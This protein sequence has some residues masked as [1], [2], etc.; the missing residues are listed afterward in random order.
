MCTSVSACHL[1][2]QVAMKTVGAGQ[3]MEVAAAAGVTSALLPADGAGDQLL[4]QSAVYIPVLLK[5]IAKGTPGGAAPALG[6]LSSSPHCMVVFGCW[7]VRES[8]PSCVIPA[9]RW[10]AI[11]WLILEALKL[12][13]CH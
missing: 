10:R 9:I 2:L 4:K 3:P 13:T 8:Q 5:A 7:L 1:K 11:T 6:N 12:R